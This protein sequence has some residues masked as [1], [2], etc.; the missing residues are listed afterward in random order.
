MRRII[1]LNGPPKCGKDTAAEII[2]EQLKRKGFRVKLLKLAGPIKRVV[3]ALFNLTDKEWEYYDSE[4][5]DRH[6]ELFF[7]KRCRDFQISVSEDWLKPFIGPEVFAQLLAREINKNDYYDV[8]VISDCGFQV[9]VD[10]VRSRLN[11]PQYYRE[12]LI[13]LSRA[14]CTFDNDS[15]ESVYCNRI[16]SWELNNNGSKKDLEEALMRIIF[17]I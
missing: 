15:R 17:S 16:D 5:K 6:L 7:G 12:T 8:F 3:K 1:Y 9:E 14:H 2:N 13:R 4:G 11:N 10:S